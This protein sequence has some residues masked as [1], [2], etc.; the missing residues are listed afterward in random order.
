[1]DTSQAQLLGRWRAELPG[2]SAPVLLQLTPHPELRESVHGTLQ[3][4]GTTVLLSGD[5]DQGQLTLEESTDGKHISANWLGTV[6]EGSCG[7][8]IRGTWN[9]DTTPP[10]SIPFVLRKQAPE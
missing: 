3:R 6:Q 4:D 7:K 1:M 5:V 2:R 8:E 9:S 10:I